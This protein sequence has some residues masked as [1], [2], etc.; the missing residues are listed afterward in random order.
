VGVEG[1]GTESFAFWAVFLCFIYL[2]RMLVLS[3]ELRHVLRKYTSLQSLLA[4]ETIHV[5]T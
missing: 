4:I 5:Y 3:L 2:F 1:S